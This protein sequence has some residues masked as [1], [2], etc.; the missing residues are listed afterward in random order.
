MG[1]SFAALCCDVQ[2]CAWF[3]DLSSALI[4]YLLPSATPLVRSNS[5][6]CAAIVLFGV[7]PRP[8]RH[9]RVTLDSLRWPSNE[10]RCSRVAALVVC[11]GRVTDVAVS[12]GRAAPAV[13]TGLVRAPVPHS[14]VRTAS[15]GAL[16]G[17][18]CPRGMP[19]LLPL[20]LS[21]VVRLWFVG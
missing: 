9:T 19:R 8:L 2:W 16:T 1:R 21:F 10:L 14:R 18:Q 15:R 4:C 20:Q 6:V 5:C 11:V 17:D 7:L 3:D 12:R 13:G